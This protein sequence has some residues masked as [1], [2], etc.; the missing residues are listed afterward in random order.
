MFGFTPVEGKIV[1]DRG[2]IGY[3]GRRLYRVVVDEPE[4]FFH[5]D[6]ERGEEDLELVAQAG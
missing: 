3:R 4:N 5:L 6:T 1:E 2:A